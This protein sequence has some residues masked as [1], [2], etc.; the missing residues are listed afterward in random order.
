MQKL[1]IKYHRYII[2]KTK[3]VVDKPN[4]LIFKKLKEAIESKITA[5]E[6]IE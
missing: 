5:I 4:T 3:T 6:G 1:P 2:E